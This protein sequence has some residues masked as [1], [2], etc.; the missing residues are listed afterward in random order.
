[1]D[2]RYLQLL[3]QQ[4]RKIPP[5]TGLHVVVVDE[6]AHY[7]TWP[8]KKPRDAF[9]DTLRDLVSRGR[10]AGIVVIAATQKPAADIIPT[11]LR[12]LFG[13]RWALRCTTNAASDTI[14][15]TGWAT[16]NT[17]AATVK[18]TARGVGWLL[19]ETGTPVRLRA[20]HLTDTNLHTL[21]R[22]AW[23]LRQQGP[24][25]APARGANAGRQPTDPGLGPITPNGDNSA[26]RNRDEGTRP[27]H[28]DT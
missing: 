26:R 1:M 10:A 24:T 25:A 8:D 23:E 12:D 6:L 9:T 5:G 22:R 14:L 11:S 19:H 7:L 20:H 18:P 21:A 4:L 13:Y 17:S 3:G 2:Q 16:N 28:A 15:G 27:D